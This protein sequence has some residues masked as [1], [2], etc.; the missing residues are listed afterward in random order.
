MDMNENE[1][2]NKLKLFTNVKNKSYWS[3]DNALSSVI[4]KNLQ[5][6]ASQSLGRV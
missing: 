6:K 5:Y 2:R 4:T 1:T 3:Y